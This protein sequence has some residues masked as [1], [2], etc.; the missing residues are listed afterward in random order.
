M[1]PGLP[2]NDGCGHRPR[3]REGQPVGGSLGS[4]PSA[5]LRLGSRGSSHA[6]QAPQTS[7]DRKPRDEGRTIA[8]DTHDRTLQD[9]LDQATKAGSGRSLRGALGRAQED[10]IEQRIQEERQR[11]LQELQSQFEE[12]LKVLEERERA[13]A[14]ARGRGRP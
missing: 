8:D 12:R 9:R 7:V 5:K 4:S 1:L 3:A 2:G 10:A 13:V 6:S 11:I 14:D